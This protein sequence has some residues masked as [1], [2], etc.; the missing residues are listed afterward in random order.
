[1]GVDGTDTKG[2]LLVVGVISFDLKCE[3]DSDK[4]LNADFRLLCCDSS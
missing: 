1:M 4:L 3:V 2:V